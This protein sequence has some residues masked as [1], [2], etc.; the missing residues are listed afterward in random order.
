MKNAD[1]LRTLLLSAWLIISWQTVCFAQDSLSAGPDSCS[2]VS[3]FRLRGYVKDLQTAAFNSSKGSLSTASLVHNRINFRYDAGD[4]FFLRVELRNRFLYGE[5]VRA[6]PLAAE[7]M[8][9]DDGLYD[10]SWN[11]ATDTAFVLNSSIDRALVSWSGKKWDITL[12]RQRINWGINLVWN[13]NDIFNAFNYFDFDYEERPGTDAI[14]VQYFSGNQS[15]IE[16]AGKLN[17]N[18]KEQVAALMYRSNYRQYD[19]QAFA[20]ICKEDLVAGAGWAGSIRNTGFKGEASLF[21]PYEN[22]FDST[23]VFSGSLA[24]DRSFG[25]SVF[26]MVSYLYNSSEQVSTGNISTIAATSLSAKNLMPFSHSF[27][28]QASK[29]INPLLNASLAVMYSPYQNSLILFPSAGV[30]I[31]N[32]WELSLVAQ[33][34]FSEVHARYRGLGNAVFLRLR[35]SY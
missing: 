33:S 31:S 16:L 15:S 3:A 21:L 17:G 12:G 30:S 1:W 10:L 7:R 20:G 23:G 2:R 34:F 19:W 32:D 35:W 27:F 4:H 29:S 18:K 11:L 8:G 25:S 13:P 5:Q 14:R 26:G 22:T 6:N 28:L 9:K 24:F